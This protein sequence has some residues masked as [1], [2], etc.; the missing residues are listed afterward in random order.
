MT[1]ISTTTTSISHTLEAE[2][3]KFRK[4]TTERWE[5]NP[6][7]ATDYLLNVIKCNLRH[8]DAINMLFSRLPPQVAQPAKQIFETKRAQ[9]L[10]RERE[11]NQNETEARRAI[12]DVAVKR[13]K[14][15][16]PENILQVDPAIFDD[17][18]AH[19]LLFVSMRFV[20]RGEGW[21]WEWGPNVQ[22]VYGRVRNDSYGCHSGVTNDYQQPQWQGG[23]EV[24]PL[25]A[26]Q[27]VAKNRLSTNFPGNRSEDTVIGS[28]EFHIGN[29]TAI[30]SYE[31]VKKWIS[32]DAVDRMGE[33]FGILIEDDDELLEGAETVEDLNSI[34]DG[35]LKAVDRYND[36][37]TQLVI[38][39]ALARKFAKTTAEIEEI[40]E[41]VTSAIG[42]YEGDRYR[43]DLRLVRTSD[44]DCAYEIVDLESYD[45]RLKEAEIIGHTAFNESYEFLGWVDDIEEDLAS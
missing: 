9:E 1:T 28:F 43:K 40:I 42:S 35:V 13:A 16:T 33:F 37:K 32:E 38:N 18:A 10:A 26:I 6:D 14:E 19:N 21:K 15:A 8:D 36:Y 7:A 5:K 3:E 41:E 12:V 11:E 17:L 27:T 45:Y 29:R 2:V 39:V 31:N 25:D 30:V 34:L 44:D 4:R 23:I 24:H 22:C 20:P